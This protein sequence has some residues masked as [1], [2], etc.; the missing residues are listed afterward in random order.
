MALR[1]RNP[2]YYFDDI[3]A[4]KEKHGFSDE[5]FE[6]AMALGVILDRFT[7]KHPDESFD[8]AFVAALLKMNRYSH[9]RLDEEGELKF[10][11]HGEKERKA[12][13]EIAE[14]VAEQRECERR[15]NKGP[16]GFIRRM[17]ND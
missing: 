1:Y 3:G 7:Q 17:I 9:D 2:G 4:L 13:R 8:S 14:L 5:Q 11:L 16:M 6:L 12:A 15:W 10:V